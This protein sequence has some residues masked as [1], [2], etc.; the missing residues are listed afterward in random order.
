MSKDFE[1]EDSF[2]DYLE[3]KVMEN[4]AEEAQYEYAFYKHIAGSEEF[5]IIPIPNIDGSYLSTQEKLDIASYARTNNN[6]LL[7]RVSLGDVAV[8]FG[9]EGG[10]IGIQPEFCAHG[11]PC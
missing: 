2:L 5:D 7:Y 10:L 1:D 3:E 6:K 11:F 8:V 9:L 4:H